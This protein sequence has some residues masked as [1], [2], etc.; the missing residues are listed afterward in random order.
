[1]NTDAK[2]FNKILTNQIQE[3]TKKIIYL[4]QVG[5]ILEMQGWRNIWKSINVIDHIKE[6]KDKTLHGHLIRCG[7]S[8]WH[9]PT[10]IH[11]KSLEEIWDTMDIP[12]H[13]KEPRKI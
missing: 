7:K 10:P 5:F 2:M 1:M 4:D 13:D 9:N 11:F 6:L 3:H 12:K 8:L